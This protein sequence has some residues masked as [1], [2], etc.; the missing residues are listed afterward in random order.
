MIIETREVLARYGL[1]ESE[2]P[3]VPADD[4]NFVDQISAILDAPPGDYT[5]APPPTP[6]EPTNHVVPQN[7]AGV[8]YPSAVDILAADGDRHRRRRP[9]RGCRQ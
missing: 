8:P 7:V 9:R 2:V 3:V 1:S 6:T 4:A 5:I